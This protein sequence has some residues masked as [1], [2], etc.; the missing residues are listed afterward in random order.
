M[1]ELLIYA[2]EM[3]ICS[4]ALLI[5]YTLLLDRRVSFS[6]CRFYLIGSIVLATLIPLLQIPVWSPSIAPSSLV[7]VGLVQ[8][9]TTTNSMIGVSPL[10]IIT[11]LY[12]LGVL[13]L[14]TLL[15]R[16][17]IPIHRLIRHAEITSH[18]GIRMVRTQQVIASCS[19]FHTIYLSKTLSDEELPIILAHETS[20]IA[21]HHS[22]EKVL[23][24]C[25]KA[26]LWWNPFVWIAARQL[27]EVHEFEA[28]NDVLQQGYD[29]P[30][31]IHIIFKQLFG[32]APAI[33]NGFH[34]SLTKKR[35]TMMTTNQKSRFSLL[36]T[37]GI[38][39]V[40]ALLFTLF[41]FTT[42]A[43]EP[44]APM[45]NKE[46][47]KRARTVTE[48]MATSPNGS[49]E[50]FRTWVMGQ[51]RYPENAL[52]AGIEGKVVTQFTVNTDGTLSDFKTLQSPNQDLSDEVI[53]CLRS[54]PKWT[55]AKQKGKLVRVMFSLP[56][57]FKLQKTAKK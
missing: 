56:V 27:T 15:L 7:S 5:A 35:F 46:V 12:A 57:D 55:P 30:T 13:F 51:V 20:H 6:F 18:Q 2:L 4:G 9:M 52:K 23:M 44:P 19:L 33:A 49:L 48:T 26:F 34:N 45:Q 11:L 10:L 50:K 21:H 8:S 25:L 53:R 16:Q 42:R 47:E 14:L 22:L 17:F 3:L 40:V 39:P 24:E 38:I 41:S 43:A 32:C 37:A 29:R 54:S 36:R 1:K 28:D 31:Y